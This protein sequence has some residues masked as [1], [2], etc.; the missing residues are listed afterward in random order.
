MVL[1]ASLFCYKNNAIYTACRYICQDYRGMQVSDEIYKSVL[2]N[3]L[4]I[5]FKNK[6]NEN[7]TYEGGRFIDAEIRAGE[8]N[9]K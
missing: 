1:L 8:E 7:E 9:L 2:S 6:A 4:F 3:S 5:P